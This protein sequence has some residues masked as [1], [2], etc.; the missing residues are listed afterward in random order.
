MIGCYATGDVSGRQYVGGLVGWASQGE[1]SNSYATGS[2]DASIDYAGGLAGSF[3]FGTLL[4][5]YSTGAVSC[6]G[7]NVG[8]LLGYSNGNTITSCYWD[9]QTSGLGTS[10]GGIGRTTTELLSPGTYIGWDFTNTWWIVNA[11]TRPFLRVEW[12]PK[13][14]TSHQLQL[15]AMDLT[16]DYVLAGD[17]N[18]SDIS[19]PASM[20]GTIVGSTGGFV[21]V[22]NSS[23]SF[24]GSF[25]GRNH[26]ITGLYINRPVTNYVGLFGWV[27]PG[28]IIKNVG[29]V[30]N[31]I[32][33]QDHVGSLAGVNAGSTVM[34][35]SSTG[36][37][38]GRAYVGGLVASV[39]NGFVEDSHSTGDVD[40][41]GNQ[42]GG[43]VGYAYKSNITRSYATGYIT[44]VQRLGGILGSQEYGNI[45][46]SYSTG[47]VQGTGNDVGGFIGH[48]IQ[49]NVYNSYSTGNATGDWY[50][51]GFIG[52]TNGAVQN[53]YSTG[54][55]TGSMY[56]GGFVGYNNANLIT[57]CFWDTIASGTMTGIGGGTNSGATGKTTTE[58]KTQSTF[59]GWD[60]TNIWHMLEGFT[61]PIF[62]WRPLDMSSAGID[63]IRI[64]D[65]PNAG[66]TILA[67]G[68]VPLDNSIMGY[69]AGFNDTF[70]YVRDVDASWSL[71][72]GSVPGHMS[73]ELNITG[74]S[75][76]TVSYARKVYSSSCT[77]L[78][79][80]EIDGGILMVFE[81]LFSTEPYSFVSYNL[82]PQGGSLLSIS[83]YMDGM[84][85]DSAWLD[86]VTITGF[87]P[88]YS[89][90][91][92][93]YFGAGETVSAGMVRVTPVPHAGGF[94]P[95]GS[96]VAGGEEDVGSSLNSFPANS[97][98][99]GYNSWSSPTAWSGM[100]YAMDLYYDADIS[101]TISPGDVRLTPVKVFAHASGS[102]DGVGSQLNA[103]A[104]SEEHG[105]L[106]VGDGGVVVRYH[107]S[108]G[109]WVFSN[110]MVPMIT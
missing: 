96:T 83:W 52:T 62:Q 89:P 74:H 103:V 28:S 69:A 70:G 92:H 48:N 40:G 77:F 101:S 97:I 2:V 76:I 23:I 37:V 93:I 35:C 43:L 7:V 90:G 102:A 58:M 59:V 22:G 42:V 109:Q 6:P 33:G 91:D 17:L 53:S 44:G 25:D 65:T 51:G 57:N 55:A 3:E 39:Y 24:T 66:A 98:F 54:S 9:T 78:V 63:Y 105:V 71:A 13:I 86:Q 19:N 81:Q 80:Y 41:T 67:S 87:S 50:V 79:S 84:V 106:A 108:G 34:N 27:D 26:T 46:N 95:S 49:G 68:S 12:S 88:Q 1:M 47:N 36:S 20:W 45:S 30:G 107:Y 104:S 29:L 61:Y 21:S 100:P 15:M 32:T 14:R 60:F 11:N 82:E 10:P 72:T 85:G 5:S 56:V 38:L 4:E 73:L 8:G 99:M 31:N 75:L 64:V 110:P 18:V 16:T 94:Y